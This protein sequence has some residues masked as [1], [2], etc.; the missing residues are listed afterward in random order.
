MNDSD[1]IVIKVVVSM[2]HTLTVA[3]DSGKLSVAMVFGMLQRCLHESCVDIY[4]YYI[5]VTYLDV[6]ES[7]GVQ[8]RPPSR[9]FAT[10]G[11]ILEEARSW[12]DL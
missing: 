8:R 11:V 6:V 5:I 7:S 1:R 12:I 9:P 4:L 3:L 10:C 2:S